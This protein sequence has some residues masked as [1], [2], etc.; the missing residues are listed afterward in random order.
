MDHAERTF[1]IIFKI[2]L[3]YLLIAAILM[4]IDK[5]MYDIVPNVG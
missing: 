3:I 2:G 4:L 5:F 1:K